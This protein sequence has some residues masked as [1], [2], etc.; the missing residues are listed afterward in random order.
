[1]KGK[2]DDSPV[3]TLM[4]GK[5]DKSHVC[6]LMT[7]KTNDSPV[8]TLITGKTIKV[9]SI[10]L[11]PH[12]HLIGLYSPVAGITVPCTPIHPKRCI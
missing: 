6:T 5:R 11:H 2:I 10:S 4:T 12:H 7:G 3:T 9:V 8:P 1:M